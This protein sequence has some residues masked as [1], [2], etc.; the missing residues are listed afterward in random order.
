MAIGQYFNDVMS[1]LAWYFSFRCRS[2]S[3][4]VSSEWLRNDKNTINF[5]PFLLTPRVVIRHGYFE[6]RN[7]ID[8]H[9]RIPRT[10]IGPDEM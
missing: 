9:S 5:P 3:L 1:S 4:K 2:R 10:W 7:G 8:Q 6:P